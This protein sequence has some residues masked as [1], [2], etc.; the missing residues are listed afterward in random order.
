[1][2]FGYEKLDELLAGI[3]ALLGCILAILLI[4]YMVQTD[5]MYLESNDLTRQE[6]RFTNSQIKEANLRLRALNND[7]TLILDDLNE[8]L[9]PEIR[10]KDI[11]GS[12]T[13]YLINNAQDTTVVVCNGLECKKN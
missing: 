5:D 9:K 4:M 10:A 11:L 1:M 2:Q 12:E 7:N 3:S 13:A 8:C 6:M